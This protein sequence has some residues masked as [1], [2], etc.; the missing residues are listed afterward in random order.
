MNFIEK[1]LTSNTFKR[2]MA[3]LFLGLILFLFRDFMS[4]IFL[5]L[6]ETIVVLDI[7]KLIHKKLGFKKVLSK[8]ITNII[9]FFLVLLGIVGFLLF[10][11]PDI[12]NQVNLIIT[13]FKDFDFSTLTSLLEKYNINID[14]ET[15]MKG[16]SSI[17]GLTFKTFNY[18]KS[19][20][21][22]IGLSFLL[23]FMY[24]L[25]E[26]KLRRFFTRFEKGRSKF[27]YTYYKNLAKKFMKSFVV[28]IEMQLVIS[29]INSALSCIVLSLLGFNNV[30][31][32]GLMMFMLGLIPVLGVI[33]SFIPLGICAFQVGGISKVIS[34]LVMIIA[35]HMLESYILN[36]KIMST[37][38]NLPIFITFAVLILSEHF[39]GPWGMI[40][41]IPIFVFL[42][43]LVSG[44]DSEIS[45]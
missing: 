36:P 21:V 12:V 25:E 32:L 38:V 23:T 2:V 13:Q 1:N 9:S 11:I 29:F 39:I 16:V 10:F 5:T 7:S 17:N 37:A 34:V 6:I 30:F 26:D 27:L 15:I 8:K 28:V 20:G 24:I 22:N 43:E 19:T 35:L 33:I 42:I 4:L 41:G 14:Q 3:L 44:E 18:V 45:I 31:I 40:I